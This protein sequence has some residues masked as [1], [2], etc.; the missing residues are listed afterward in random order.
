MTVTELGKILVLLIA[1]T[2]IACKHPMPEPNTLSDEQGVPGGNTFSAT[3]DY[4]LYP[5]DKVEV[6]VHGYP[7]FSGKFGVDRAGFIKLSKVG[8]IRAQGRSAQLLATAL[9]IKLKPFVK[10][11]RVSVAVAETNSYRVTFAGIIRRPGV[12]VS[13]GPTSLIEGLAIAGGILED[14]EN[15]NVIVVRS[16]EKGN[17]HRFSVNYQALMLGLAKLDNFRLERGDFI[18]VHH[19]D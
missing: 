18:Y 16:D 5:G 3:G 15:T 6:Y 10:Y 12:H 1:T 2:L 13:D 19:A 4:I 9:R 11:P 17:K 7:M 14:P 8:E